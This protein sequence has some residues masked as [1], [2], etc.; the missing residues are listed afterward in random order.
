MAV[1]RITRAV[2]R[3]AEKVWPRVTDWPAHAAQVPLTS[4]T[5]VT[6]SPPGVGTV[7]VARTGLGRVGF[8]DPMEVVRWEPPVEGGTGRLRLEKRGRVIRGWAE[9]EVRPEGSGSVVVWVEELW[10]RLLPRLFDPLVRRV[11]R[12]VFGR[13]LDGLLAGRSRSR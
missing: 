7:F 12:L 6:P 8:D 1:I 2:P 4:I 9:I 10:I 5:V 3:P 11:G 13:A